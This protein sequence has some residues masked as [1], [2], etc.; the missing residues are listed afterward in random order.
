MISSSSIL[1]FVLVAVVGLYLSMVLIGSRHWSGGRDG[2]SMFGHYLSRTMALL[3][4]S[5]A[6]VILVTRHDLRYDATL[7]GVSSLSPKTRAIIR[8]LNPDHPITIEAFV[9]AQVP[10]LYVQ[11]RYNLVSLLKEFNAMS[12]RQD[13]RAAAR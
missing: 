12:R 5:V 13:Q 7:G 3:V 9:S 10:E 6:L 11:T 1:Y 4:M 8:Q 2:H